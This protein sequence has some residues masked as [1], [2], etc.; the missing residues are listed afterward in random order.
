[1]KGRT[2][3]KLKKIDDLGGAEF[4]SCDLILLIIAPTSTTSTCTYVTQAEAEAVL[5]IPLPGGGQC[6]FSTGSL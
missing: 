6:W 4:R 3:G 2:E 1:M 5:C